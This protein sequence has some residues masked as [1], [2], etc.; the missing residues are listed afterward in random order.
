LVSQPEEGAIRNLAASRKRLGSLYVVG[1]LALCATSAT[2][3]QSLLRGIV[4]DSSGDPIA[5]A[6]VAIVALH[7]AMRT[8]DAGRFVFDKLPAGEVEVSVRRIGYE[9]RTVKV[10]LTTAAADSITV[11]LTEL[12]E[13]MSAIAVSAQEAHR[14]QGI[15]DFYWRRARGIGAFFTKEEIRARN[16]SA[17]S[18]MLRSTPGV[19][20][21]RAGGGKGIRFV[22]PSNAR[23]DCMPTIWLDGQRALGLELDDLSAN[24][25]EGM[26]LYQSLS[27]TPPQFSHGGSTT[28]CG[29]IVVWSRVPGTS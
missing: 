4:T 20:F 3:Q 1:V 22:S 28:P 26:E 18:D 16:V 21:V 10:M 14:R 2:A 7:H 23:R 27:T 15:E 13:V 19:R 25:I 8:N 12:A 6:A 5:D 24:D 11:K 9:P 29:T 17:P